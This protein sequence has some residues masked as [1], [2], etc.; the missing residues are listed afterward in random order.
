MRVFLKI[1]FAIAFPLLIWNCFNDSSSLKTLVDFVPEN[2]LVVLKITDLNTLRQDFQ[3]NEVLAVFRNSEVHKLLSANHPVLKNI[4]P[5]GNVL[6]C[7]TPG[8]DSLI[9]YTLIARNDTELFLLDSLKNKTVETLAYNNLHINRITLEKETVFTAVRD[10]I[11][12]A[13]S[14]QKLL[15]D[16]LLDITEKNP[17]FK[18]AVQIGG[19][20]ELTVIRNNPRIIID[21]STA[22]NLAAQMTLKVTIAPNGITASGVA[23]AG[24]STG[25]L[26]NIFK[27]Q[28]PQ[29]HTISAI[30]PINALGSLSFTFN[31]AAM[32]IDN[33]RKYRGDTLALPSIEIFET[34]TEIGDIHLNEG[35]SIVLSSI[36]ASL[37]NDALIPM[38]TENVSFR[39]VQLYDF[40]EPNLFIERLAP[41][42]RSTKPTLVFRLDRYFVFAENMATAEKMITTYKINAV[43]LNAPFFKNTSRQLGT[44]SS[45]LL[46]YLNGNTSKGIANVLFPEIIS[47]ENIK[48]L[49]KYPLSALQFSYD[50]DFAHVN[51]ASLEVATPKQI[52]GRISQ[53]FS[54]EMDN[55]ILGNPQ[56]FSNHRTGGYDVV[57]QDFTN[58]LYLLSSNGKTL[59]NKQLDGPI[60][61]KIHEVD[62][63]RNKKKQLVFTTKNKLYVLDRNAKAVAPFPIVFKDDIT[64][65]LSVFDYDNNRKY[66]FAVVQGKEVLLYDN[67][68]KV[69]KGF[70]FKKA[71]STIVLPVRHIRMNNKDYIVI[72]E[73]NGSLNILSRVGKS[74]VSVSKKF[75][76]SEIPVTVEGSSFVV[77]TS[78]NTKER[79]SQ[80]GKVTSQKLGVSESYWFEIAYKTKVT[81]DD[82][83]LRI[84]GKLI[85]LPFGIYTQPALY[86]VNRK[87]YITV[88]ETQEKKVYVYG[89]L[90]NLLSGFPIYG[91]SAAALCDING[92]GKLH[93]LVMGTEKEVIL[94]QI[95]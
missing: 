90:G 64:Q 80:K 72:A 74:R 82:N 54:K 18:K 16:V 62:I 52:T 28:L 5:S 55:S 53:I 41:L 79:I 61:G 17:E 38:L 78:E 22:L 31:N 39:D 57:F 23:M 24:D 33:L 46:L 20:N 26:T 91:T 3:Q 43:L 58:R 88:T 19:D 36:D 94:Y 83:L 13:S 75:K 76:F 40:S 48:S 7:L 14:S 45:L 73:E 15:Q 6:L 86:R 93:L 10:S 35:S 51:F 66:R 9:D 8:R 67:N 69:V 65:P 2:T 27:G 60:L 95:Q 12:I 47:E 21:D 81:L 29:Q 25:Y 63:L 34:I 1:S 37:T 42:V 50:R 11:F 70:S 59:W 49:K 4:N 44:A 32:L 87:T 85:E 30:H 56:F 68:G 71:G 77:I 92:N 84:N 89:T